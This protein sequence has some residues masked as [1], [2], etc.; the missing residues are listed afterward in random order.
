SE[1]LGILNEKGL[2]LDKIS[3]KPVDLA[4]LLHAIE[5]GAISS[6]MGKGLLKESIDTKKRP[7]EIINEKGVSQ[8]T[9]EQQIRDVI[10]KV[11]SLNPKAVE[12]YKGGREAALAFL[13]GKVMKETKG[14]ANPGAV[15][16]LLKALL[17]ERD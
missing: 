6:K 9:D 13:I 7:S 5:N 8:I 16:N 11:L 15:N 12:D 17:K 2:S 14:K 1:L 10:M 4:Q 3:F